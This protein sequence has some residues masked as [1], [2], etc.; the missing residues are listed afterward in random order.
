MS[1]FDR[2]RSRIA[3]DPVGTL[4][5]VGIEVKKGGGKNT[6]FV[7]Y[8]VCP[9][10]SDT[11]GSASVV[12]SGKRAGDIHCKQCGSE[13][14]K[15][16]GGD[17]FEWLVKHWSIGGSK[18][19]YEAAKRFAEQFGIEV[20]RPGRNAAKKGKAKPLDPAVVLPALMD[21]D[22][23]AWAREWFEERGLWDEELMASLSVGFHGGNIVYLHQDREGNV[24]PRHRVQWQ[25]GKRVWDGGKDPIYPTFWP[26]VPDYDVEQVKEVLLCEGESDV[27]AAWVRLRLQERGI[28][29][30]CWCYGSATA[31]LNATGFPDWLKGK[32]V[33]VVYDNDT[34]QGP[35]W[36][37]HR[38]PD[39]KKHKDMARRRQSLFDNVAQVLADYGCDVHLAHVAIDPADHWGADLRDW[40]DAGKEFGDLPTYPFAECIGTDKVLD[41]GF[42]ELKEID[43]DHAGRCSYRFRCSLAGIE[44]EPI[45]IPTTISVDC[46]K[47]TSPACLQCRVPNLVIEGDTFK[48]TKH[49]QLVARIALRSDSR[50]GG[51]AMND[52]LEIP[53]KCPR[54]K[55]KVAETAEGYLWGARAPEVTSELSEILVVSRQHPSWSGAMV[56]TGNMVN[57]VDTSKNV[58]VVS[59]QRDESREKPDTRKQIT[60]LKDRFPSPGATPNDLYRWASEQIEFYAQE[61][62]RIYGREH[63]HLATILAYH[64]VSRIKLH[65]KDVR[66]WIDFLVV[67]DPRTGKSKIAEEI[68]RFYDLGSKVELGTHFT[69]AGLTLGLDGNKGG[70]V[71]PGLV[72][73]NHSGLLIMDEIQ[74]MVQTGKD[75]PYLHLTSARGDGLMNQAKVGSA[76][77]TPCEVRLIGISN[78]MPER[79]GGSPCMHLIDL[80]GNEQSIA[81]LDFMLWMRQLDRGST[82]EP[83]E[84]ITLATM[85][86]R[87]MRE[88]VIRAWSMK[89]DDVL[90]D[91]G[92][93]TACEGWSQRLDHELYP[94]DIPLFTRDEKAFSALRIAV[95][96]ANWT[97]SHPEGE[98]DKC[99][100]RTE[101]V[102][103][104]IGFL[105]QTFHDCG[106]YEYSAVERAINTGM[107]YNEAEDVLM[108]ALKPQDAAD[109]AAR[110]RQVSGGIR[111]RMAD[112]LFGHDMGDGRRFLKRLLG[113]RVL[114][115][116][117]NTGKRGVEIV[118]ALTE[119]GADLVNKLQT[120]CRVRPSWM[121]ARVQGRNSMT[122]QYGSFESTLSELLDLADMDP[123]RKPSEPM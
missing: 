91:D 80:M 111:M 2:C 123:D 48:T 65:G 116:R 55:V 45:A 103:M 40:V 76:V 38:A 32:K 37:L 78:P 105:E 122:P 82:P 89:P 27:L 39:D 26:R 21:S 63:M 114:R 20:D 22:D 36:E 117:N 90:L 29:A 102:T 58:F 95:A 87:T 93:W 14:G 69:K 30:M 41:K 92:V 104:A 44:S 101:H 106:Y 83:M 77:R 67:G 7:S 50:G 3:Q 28:A 46:P 25:G 1:L 49:P 23:A 79:Q 33:T 57:D 47:G 75:S 71:S 86:A 56:L 113:H 5:A 74:D 31:H 96:I 118:Y 94:T 9:C 13:P 60:P 112:D 70:R 88:L 121:T 15:G 12:R 17:F 99:R 72:T 120:M 84:G 108:K 97:F 10:C 66:G 8:V 18:A 24:R 109:L 35:V 59:K 61:V 107:D 52:Y 115:A 51:R 119:C 6:Q 54:N 68:Q 81:R 110:L 64:S 34:F 73:L 16:N 11:D 53:G 43:L 98:P 4:Q 62:T 100:V 19:N 85:P 42:H